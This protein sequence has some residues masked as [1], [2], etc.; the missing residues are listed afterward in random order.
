M[1]CRRTHRDRSWIRPSEWQRR[2]PENGVASSRPELQITGG[3][4]I[5]F[6]SARRV[7]RSELADF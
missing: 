4:A 5:D 6:G 1:D 7:L 3:E 2:V